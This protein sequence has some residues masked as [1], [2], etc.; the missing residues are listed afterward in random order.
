MSTLPLFDLSP[1]LNPS[2]P[3]FPSPSDQITLMEQH[4][5]LIERLIYAL[6]TWGVLLIQGHGIPLEL[7]N[8]LHQES[9]SFFNQSLDQKKEIDLIHRGRAWRGYFEMG[10]E[11]TAGQVDLKEGLYFGIEHPP[12][13]PLV[14]NQTPMHGSNQ[15]PRSPSQ[16]KTS[17]CEYMNHA[18]RVAHTLLQI[19]GYGIGLPITYFKDRFTQSSLYHTHP[20]LN[21]DPTCLFRIFHYPTHPSSPLNKDSWGVGEHTDM[22]FLTLVLQDQVG[23][24]QIKKDQTWM[25]IPPLAWV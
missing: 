13:H 24:L 17:V 4:S 5:A 19:I 23:G 3:S 1:F 2:D 8:L 15:W 10:L 25:D 22:G 6:E 7:Q 20:H 21:P 18:Q 9:L 14:Q 12:T 11:Y 16:F